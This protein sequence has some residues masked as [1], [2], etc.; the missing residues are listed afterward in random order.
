MSNST[1]LPQLPYDILHLVAVQLRRQDAGRT[2]VSLARA[3]RGVRAV[4]QPLIDRRL[5]ITCK[6]AHSDRLKASLSNLTPAAPDAGPAPGKKARHP[7]LARERAVA[8]LGRLQK[9]RE[10]CLLSCPTP[11]HFAQVQRLVKI[12][13]ISTIFSDVQHLEISA[14]T[15]GILISHDELKPPYGSRSSNLFRLSNPL[16]ICVQVP[17]LSY[18][19]HIFYIRNMA[20]ASSA[21]KRLCVHLDGRYRYGQIKLRPL[22][23]PLLELVDVS[24]ELSEAASTARGLLNH[25]ESFSQLRVEAAI[26]LRLSFPNVTSGSLPWLLQTGME[27]PTLLPMTKQQAA[28]DDAL[29]LLAENP[30]VDSVTLY[31]VTIAVGKQA[32]CSRGSVSRLLPTAGAAAYSTQFS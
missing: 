11:T 5:A 4:V 12:L 1:A 17:A 9:F 18:P 29:A 20:E 24:R 22:H 15:L 23:I 8:K 16:S 10:L 31:N 28:M 19:D 13:Q 3:C 2:L 21:V 25:L 26:R 32:R 7:R 30:D 14:A 6:T 27:S